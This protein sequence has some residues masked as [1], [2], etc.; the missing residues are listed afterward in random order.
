MNSGSAPFEQLGADIVQRYSGLKWP[1]LKKVSIQ[2][3]SFTLRLRLFSVASEIGILF[4]FNDSQVDSCSP[5]EVESLN[6][7]GSH[8]VEA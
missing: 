6:V 8:N 1:Q 3:P 5:P 7:F 2:V 4:E